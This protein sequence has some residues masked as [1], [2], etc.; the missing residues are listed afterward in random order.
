MRTETRTLYRYS[1]LSPEAQG[2]ACE[3]ARAAGW[4][5]DCWSAEWRQA[6]EGA[7]VALGWSVKGWS[8]GAF[9]DADCRLEVPESGALV[10]VRAWKFLQNSGAF[11]VIAG[12]CPFTGYCGDESFLAPLR[13]FQAR[14]D[15]RLTL[16]ELAEQ[17]G[18]A[19]ARDWRADME[20]SLSDEAIGESLECNECE[21]DEH[22]GIVR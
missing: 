16:A 19:W 8:V 11:D 6:L 1:E 22:G 21:F 14:P 17:C 18:D 9:S 2:R 15:P 10:G 5:E 13:K 7:C 12:D 20:H 3:E 4:G